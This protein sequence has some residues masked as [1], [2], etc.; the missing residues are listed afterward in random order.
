MVEVEH[1]HSHPA[2]RC[3]Q[4]PVEPPQGIAAVVKPRQAVGHCQFQPRF[5]RGAQAVRLGLAA[6]LHF[7]AHRQ[8]PDVEGIVEDIARPQV[9]RHSAPFGVALGQDHQHR[10]VTRGRAR[11]Q[12]RQKPQPLVSRGQIG[13]DDEE[14]G[15]GLNPGLE[16]VFARQNLKRVAHNGAKGPFPGHARGRIR[17]HQRHLAGA[18]E[19]RRGFREAQACIG[20]FAQPQF[21]LDLGRAQKRAHPRQQR[22]LVHRFGQVIVGPAFEP[23]DLAVA[24]G[25]GGDQDH[26]NIGGFGVGFQPF[27]DA[28]TAHVGHHHVEEDQVGALGP[29][30]PE[31]GL[32]AIGL[33]HRIAGRRELDLHD[34]AIGGHI[35][36]N[37]NAPCH[38]ML[39]HCLSPGFSHPC[40]RKVNKAFNERDSRQDDSGS[41]RG[42][43]APCAWLARGQ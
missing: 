24:V 35:V 6:Q 31:G 23:V 18:V 22:H 16:R 7:D 10:R 34:D 25:Q 33:Q 21:A 37:Q 26:G 39:R 28:D 19:A 14:V 36:H 5:D 29:G 12:V 9:E 27:A 8:F 13:G 40:S 3:H 41:C 4:H 15:R 32:T 38:R 20:V 11:T 30:K 1:H 17:C 43:R 2:S 42:N